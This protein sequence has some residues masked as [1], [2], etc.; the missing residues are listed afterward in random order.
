MKNLKPRQRLG[1]KAQRGREEGRGGGIGRRAY[2]SVVAL[3]SWVIWLIFAAVPLCSIG[4][5][6]EIRDCCSCCRCLSCDSYLS[7]DVVKG[8]C[9]VACKCV[10]GPANALGCIVSAFLLW[11]F[12][13]EAKCSGVDDVIGYSSVYGP[14]SSWFGRNHLIS[15]DGLE[16]ELTV[17]ALAECNLSDAV[18]AKYSDSIISYGQVD[19]VTITKYMRYELSKSMWWWWVFFLPAE[20]SS[21]MCDNIEGN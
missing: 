19:K 2:Y 1:K 20:K 10:L 4:I 15:A 6:I 12:A 16:A 7:A 5:W 17:L 11:Q 8:T 13:F 3:T 9:S 14:R 18:A 21:Y